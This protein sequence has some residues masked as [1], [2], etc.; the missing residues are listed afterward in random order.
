MKVLLKL[1]F[2]LIV[3]VQLKGQGKEIEK[4]YQIR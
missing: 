2:V 4:I 1:I 3:S